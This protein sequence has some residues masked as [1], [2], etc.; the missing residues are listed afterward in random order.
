MAE[1]VIPAVPRAQVHDLR[2]GLRAA[3][4]EEVATRLPALR[5][6]LAAILSTGDPLVAREVVRHAHT[7]ASSAAVLGEDLASQHA[8]K[9]ELLLVEQVDAGRPLPAEDLRAAAEHVATLEV[10]LAPW[11]TGPGHDVA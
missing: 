5:E 8:R 4:A 11:L 3:F 7:L 2:D 1:R 9:C 6:G 10:L